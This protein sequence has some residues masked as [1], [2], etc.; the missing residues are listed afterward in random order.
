MTVH[1]ASTCDTPTIALREILPLQLRVNVPTQRIKMARLADRHG[2]CVKV[3]TPGPSSFTHRNVIDCF[4]STEGLVSVFFS[5]PET[6][7]NSHT[8]GLGQPQEDVVH[9]KQELPG[10]DGVRCSSVLFMVECIALRLVSCAEPN[11]AGQRC[12]GQ[13]YALLLFRIVP[14]QCS[15]CCRRRFAVQPSGSRSSEDTVSRSWR[16][17]PLLLTTRPRRVAAPSKDV[18]RRSESS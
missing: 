3:R 5:A 11:L 17:V 8:R 13:G 4:H 14:V 18:C 1:C 16:S 6:V 10:V 9:S 2:V 12:S 15:S 7:R